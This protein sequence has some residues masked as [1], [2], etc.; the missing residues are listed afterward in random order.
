MRNTIGGVTSDK[1]AR[2]GA[3]KK[4]NND[5]DVGCENDKIRRTG[6]HKRWGVGVGANRTRGRESKRGESGC[7]QQEEREMENQGKRGKEQE[8]QQHAIEARTGGGGKHPRGGKRRT[9]VLR[10]CEVL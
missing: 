5:R 8:E 1:R 4:E 7:W 3:W 6:K 9:G 10:Q 2:I